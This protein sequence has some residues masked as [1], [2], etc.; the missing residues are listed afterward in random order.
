MYSQCVVVEIS[1]QK[2][3]Q[4]FFLTAYLSL[5][6]FLINLINEPH[7]FLIFQQSEPQQFLRNF[8]IFREFQPQLSYKVVSYEKN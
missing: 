3:N 2:S 4:H 6:Q 7:I 8:L 1:L 5:N